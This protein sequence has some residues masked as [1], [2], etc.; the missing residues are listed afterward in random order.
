GAAGV[1]SAQNFP[2]KPVRLISAYAPGGGA[3]IGLRLLGAKLTEAGWP[4]VIVENKPGGG[5]A[6]GAQATLQAPADGYTLFQCDATSF[7]INVS[8][9]KDLSYDPLKDFAP[10]MVTFS[11]PS[12]LVVPANSPAKTAADL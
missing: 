12:V 1:A 2:T 7:A 11:F 4:P 9:M 5:G 10:V 6:V 3:E 8:L